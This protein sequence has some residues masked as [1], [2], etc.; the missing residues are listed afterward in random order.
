MEVHSPTEHLHYMVVDV[1]VEQVAS[2][3]FQGIFDG[4]NRE[5]HQ[6]GYHGNFLLEG[7]KNRHPVQ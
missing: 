7:L 2:V 3:V 1:L 5:N 6:Q 4:D